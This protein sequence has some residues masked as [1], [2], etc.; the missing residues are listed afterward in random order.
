MR[1]ASEGPL[2]ARVTGLSF[3]GLSTR[4]SFDA[5]GTRLT[6]LLPQ[7]VARPREGDEVALSWAPEDLHL[8]RAG[9]RA[10]QQVGQ[11]VGA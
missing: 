5:E 3:L 1:L 11:R 9:A 2:K 4:V 6:A 10:G 8:M 7:D